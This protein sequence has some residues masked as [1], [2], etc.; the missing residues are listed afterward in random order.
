MTKTLS[1]IATTILF[2]RAH[3]IRINAFAMQGGPDGADCPC[4]RRT[5]NGVVVDLSDLGFPMCEDLPP[6]EEPGWFD[7]FVKINIFILESFGSF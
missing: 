7:W 1:K 6:Q 3:A 4:Q 5:V 2:T